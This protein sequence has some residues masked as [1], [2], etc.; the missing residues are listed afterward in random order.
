LAQPNI[1]LILSDQHRFDCLGINGHPF[2]RTPHIDRL[3]AEGLNFTQAYTPIPVC[4]PTRNC[5]LHGQW[6]TEHLAIANHDTEAPRPVKS[7]LS[8]FTR[9]LRDAGYDL[10]HVGKWGVHPEKDPVHPDYGYHRYVGVE[11]YPRWREAQGVPPLP[12]TTWEGG[13]D[14]DAGPAHSRLAWGAGETIRLLEQASLSDQPF[15]IRWDAPEPHLP[16]I[17]PE[18]YYSLY[19][20]AEIPPWPS[21]PDSLAG[22]PYI[23]GQQR[24]TWGVDGWSWEQWAPVVSRYLGQV[25]LLDAQVGRLLDTLDSLG[26][27]ESTLVIYTT[28]H[29]DLGGGHGM[30]DKHYVMYDDVVRV[31]LVARWPGHISPGS[32][33][34]AFVSHSLDLAPTFCDVA[35]I[36]PPD[37]FRGE[38][39]VPLFEGA[40]DNGRP[41]IFA[42]YHGNQFGLYSQRMVRDRRWKYVWNA[43][44]EDEL[45]DLEQ[46]PGELQ[47]LARD[48]AH[49]EELRRLRRRLIA[50]MESISDPLLNG[51]NRTQLLED[52]T[53]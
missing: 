43:T 41:D 8:T 31:P 23:Q 40:Q 6:S 21:F 11:A 7:G 14:P 49:L 35:G 2:L 26:L 46:D 33:C 37:T 51:W 16:N 27:A 9:R 1:L 22:K 3:A 38:S 20:P 5:L 17:V 15:F 30:V 47:N 10:S 24:R 19:P 29:G 45:Y 32:V 36:S 53:L 13:L 39:L 12:R 52:R 42:M 25:S 48:P 44:A 50:W 18:P 4:V 28:D 34:D